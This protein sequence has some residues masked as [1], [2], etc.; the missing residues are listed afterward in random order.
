MDQLDLDTCT[1]YD[2]RSGYGYHDF[3]QVRKLKTNASN[4]DLLNLKFY[5]LAAKD[6]HILLSEANRTSESTRVIEIGNF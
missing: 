4:D 6:A 5:V 3:F 1:E 2:T